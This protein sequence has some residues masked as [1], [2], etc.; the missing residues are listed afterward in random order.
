MREVHGVRA[1][2]VDEVGDRGD[3]VDVRVPLHE[4]PDVEVPC[5]LLT[6]PGAAEHGEH[7]HTVAPAERVQLTG[8]RRVTQP[9]QCSGWSG[10]VHMV[11]QAPG[12][13][14]CHHPGYGTPMDVDATRNGGRSRSRQ[15]VERGEE[16]AEQDGAVEGPQQDQRRR[17]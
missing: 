5:A 7:P 1:R 9:L 13:E 14:R 17:Q 15:G 10:H 6:P 12:R 8:R 16:R 3:G 2:H 11:A 4:Q